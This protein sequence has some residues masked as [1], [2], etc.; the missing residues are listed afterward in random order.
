MEGFPEEVT[1]ELSL[2][3][4]GGS[5]HTKGEGGRESGMQKQRG[6]KGQGIF[7]GTRELVGIIS[8]QPM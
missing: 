2:E 8:T 5:H 3:G 6:I 4:S 7:G 1:F